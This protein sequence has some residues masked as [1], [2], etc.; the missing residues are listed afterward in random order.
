MATDTPAIMSTFQGEIK[1]RAWNEK[2]SALLSNFSVSPTWQFLLISHWVE[3]GQRLSHDQGR[4]RFVLFQVGILLISMKLGLLARKQRRID[5][6]KATPCLLHRGTRK[7]DEM[8][9]NSLVLRAWIFRVKDYSDLL[10]LHK[11]YGVAPGK[12]MYQEWV[13]LLTS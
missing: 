4:W 6:Q 13:E 10:I 2:M 1:G 9:Q 5:T 11:F 8:A 12:F 7:R 3:W